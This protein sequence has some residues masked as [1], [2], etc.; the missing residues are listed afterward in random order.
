M[1]VLSFMTSHTPVSTI[2]ASSTQCSRNS[3]I[4]EGLRESVVEAG[5]ARAVPN[6]PKLAEA[7]LLPSP[8]HCCAEV[9]PSPRR[10]QLHSRLSDHRLCLV[11]ALEAP[12]T[13]QWVARGQAPLQLAAHGLAVAMLLLRPCRA[14]TLA[15]SVRW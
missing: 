14:L 7:L 1:A 6:L 12:V 2:A 4:S 13:Q 11:A 5:V 15:P 8:L 9:G 10:W 3:R